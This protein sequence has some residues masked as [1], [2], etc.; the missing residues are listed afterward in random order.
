MIRVNVCAE[1]NGWLFADL[2][3]GFRSAG[4][5]TLQVVVTETPVLQAD[6]WVFIRTGEASASPDFART[7]VCIHDLYEHDGMYLPSGE[8]EAV[9]KAGG[10]VLR[11]R[12]SAKSSAG[13][14][15]A[16]KAYRYWSGLWVL[17]AFSSRGRECRRSSPSAGAGA[18]IGANVPN[19]C[20]SAPG[21]W[22]MLACT[23]AS[24]WSARTWRL[25]LM[26]SSVGYRVRASSKVPA[27]HR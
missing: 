1:G 18:I 7:V 20:S 12:P 16:S 23:S 21:A 15:S 26:G 10:L 5:S 14:V 24:N 4:S 27:R 19:G 8:R 9:R 2:K 11:I 17:F 6:A 13:W 25:L 22:Q 3:D